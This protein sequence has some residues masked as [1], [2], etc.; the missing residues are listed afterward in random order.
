MYLVSLYPI[1]MLG[2]W[3]EKPE[4]AV[5]G[6]S[7]ALSVVKRALP[8]GKPH[9]IGDRGFTYHFQESSI[10]R[11]E[12]PLFVRKKR[13]LSDVRKAAGVARLKAYREGVLA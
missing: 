1:P 4:N 3:Y 6:V 7:R 5:P 11:A 12:T 13:I 8:E 9:Q 10:L 2:Y